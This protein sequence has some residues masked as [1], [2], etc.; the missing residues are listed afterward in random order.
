MKHGHD[1]AEAGKDF[2]AGVT[3][4]GAARHCGGTLVL[5][6]AGVVFWSAKGRPRAATGR[7][8][9]YPC[10]VAGADGRV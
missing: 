9:R 10:S 8:G 6:A 1:Y 2:G 4:K 7:V 3:A 5:A